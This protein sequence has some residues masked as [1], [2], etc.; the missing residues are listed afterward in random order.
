MIFSLLKH[1]HTSTISGV[2]ALILLI[3]LIVINALITN[4][5]NEYIIMHQ[6]SFTKERALSILSIWGQTGQT[7]FVKTIWIDYIFPLFYATFLSSLLAQKTDHLKKRFKGLT[8]SYLITLPFIAAF[9]DMV[10][11][12]YQVV[13][14]TDGINMPSWVFLM[15]SLASLIK[16]ACLIISLIM[17]CILYRKSLIRKTPT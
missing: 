6:L 13:Q 5:A 12:A 7:L 9:F 17:V 1:K 10:E 11:N 16:W 3:V 2:I 8:L 15:T 14:V 4:Q